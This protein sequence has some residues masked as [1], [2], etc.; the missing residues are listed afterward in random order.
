MNSELV[1]EILSSCADALRQECIQRTGSIQFV[2]AADYISVSAPPLSPKGEIGSYSLQDLVRATYASPLPPVLDQVVEG[3]RIAIAIIDQ[4]RPPVRRIVATLEEV[5][6]Q[7]PFSVQSGQDLRLLLV[8]FIIASG[9][10]V[11]TPRI[12]NRSATLI[13]NRRD[14]LMVDVRSLEGVGTRRILATKIDFSP[15]S[16][17]TMHLGRRIRLNLP[18]SALYRYLTRT[19][20]D[21]MSEIAVLF[22]AA[23]YC[24]DAYTALLLDAFD[25]VSDPE[26]IKRERSTWED[27]MRHVDRAVRPPYA[28]LM[29][30]LVPS[31]MSSKEFRMAF[32][33]PVGRA[34]ISAFTDD[35]RI[36]Y[37]IALLTAQAAST[38][39]TPG[40]AKQTAVVTDAQALLNFNT[41]LGGS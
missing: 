26:T 31:V 10:Y 27:A 25:I 36:K 20:P 24:G 16:C 17:M 32:G 3:W 7:V 18:L 1:T 12:T 39:P 29:S 37:R 22:S 8:Q 38:Q 21:M 4:P 35:M 30:L 2:R 6:P 13:L 41:L 34:H 15:L 28:E 11:G 19:L 33:R 5:H 14:R 23:G 40:E 9:W